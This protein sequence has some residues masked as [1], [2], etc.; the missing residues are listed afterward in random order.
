MPGLLAAALV[1]IASARIVATYKIL[2]N[3]TDEP[4]HL[5]AGIEWLENGTYTYEDQHPPLARVV[6]CRRSASGGRALGA[7]Q[8]H[9]LR[10]LPSARLRAQVLHNLFYSRLAML[11]F[12]WVGCAVVFLWT[13]RYAGGPAAVLATLIFTTT[14]AVLGHA[15]LATTDMALTAF[16]GAAAFSGLI[17]AERPDWKRAVVF[18]VFCGLAVASKFSALLFLPPV[19]VVIGIWRRPPA[20]KILVLMALFTLPVAVMVVW[21]AYRFTL[22]PTI[23]EGLRSVWEH[24]KEG[25]PAWLLGRRSQHGFWYYYLVAGAV[26]TPLATLILT[27]VAA[28]A[29]MKRTWLPLAFAASILAVAS[30]GSINIGIR[31]VL[32]VYIGISICC[33]I[34]ALYLWQKGARRISQRTAR[35]AVVALLVWQVVTGALCHPDYIA[36]TNEL[37]GDRP[38]RILADSDLDW[39]QDV[40]RLAKRL[41]QL[42]VPEFTFKITS[43]GYFAAGNDFP[44]FVNMPDGAHPRPGWNA[45]S[46]TQWRISGEPRWAETATPRERIGRGILFFYFP[47]HPANALPSPGSV[48]KS[49]V[50]RTPPGSSAGKRAF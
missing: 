43:P 41:F 8:R 23:F 37:A 10:G 16:T 3:T 47:E 49:P 6:G 25:H 12:F 33:G 35:A 9:V 28:I 45:V 18:G 29:L 17:W 19:L 40:G 31:H 7:G 13:A 34:A 24:N 39:G 36:Y 50:S 44:R 15:G 21:A 27:G 2:N 5:A 26:K 20:K 32:P 46:I 4:A 42:N 14:P 1:I 48:L 30:F 38:D 22:E 11:P